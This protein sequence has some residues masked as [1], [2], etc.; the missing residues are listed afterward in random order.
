MGQNLSNS[1]KDNF[2]SVDNKKAFNDGVIPSVGKNFA[3]PN[4]CTN[5]PTAFYNYTNKE[6]VQKQNP[7]G[8]K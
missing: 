5:T 2:N 8:V 3:N 6:I 7:N 4:N 1:Q